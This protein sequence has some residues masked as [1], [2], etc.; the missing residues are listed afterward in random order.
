M[1]VR[2]SITHIYITSMRERRCSCHFVRG[3][4]AGSAQVAKLSAGR[5]GSSL[6]V[7]S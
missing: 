6:V 7:C 1:S 3:A 2:I 5:C 4:A